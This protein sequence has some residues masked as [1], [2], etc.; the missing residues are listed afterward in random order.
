M[1]I[2]IE[3]KVAQ[4]FRKL[5]GNDV[6]RGLPLVKR[7]AVLELVDFMML[8]GIQLMNNSRLGINPE[9]I[10]EFVQQKLKAIREE[11]IAA[12]LRGSSNSM[13][14]LDFG[15]ETNLGNKPD[16]LAKKRKK[17]DMEILKLKEM[18][19]ANPELEKRRLQ[20]IESVED[21]VSIP[22]DELDL[23]I[24]SMV[25]PN[26]M[27]NEKIKEIEEWL[28]KEYPT[29]SVRPESFPKV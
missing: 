22:A 26:V 17:M 7:L 29:Q 23:Y 27:D 14:F 6:W 11:E 12:I 28:Q 15:V 8:H 10:E 19:F 24:I 25:V 13:N 4:C 18:I 21:K 1:N 20:I 9:E 3:R 5:L 2:L 16:A